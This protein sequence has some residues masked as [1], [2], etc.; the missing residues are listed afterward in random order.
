MTRPLRIGILGA[1]KIG[2]KALIVPARLR[3]D[4]EVTAVAARE[5][6][7]ARAYADRH[8]IP[9]VLP[10]YEAVVG[11]ED[12]DVVYNPLPMSLH[13]RWTRAALEA[14]KHVLCEKP[15]TANGDEAAEVVAVAERTGLVVME[16]FHYRYHPLMTRLLD[17]ERALKT[18]GTAGAVLFRKLMTDIAYQA[19]RAR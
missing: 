8:G 7:L 5:E 2:P 16:A 6:T 4:V 11:D 12:V 14:G 13:G 18:S 15:F 10:D 3:S 17:C 9:R 1:A 19:A